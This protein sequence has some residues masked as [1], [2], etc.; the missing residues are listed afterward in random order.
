MDPRGM[1]GYRV[2][3]FARGLPPE[4]RLPALERLPAPAP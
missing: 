3:A 2:L 1:G 4:A